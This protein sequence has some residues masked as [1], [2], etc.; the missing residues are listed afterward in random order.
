L[1]PHHEIVERLAAGQTDEPWV[2]RRMRTPVR[3]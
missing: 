3:T 1:S 2:Y